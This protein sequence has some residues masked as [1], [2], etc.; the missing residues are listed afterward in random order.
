M[1]ICYRTDVPLLF[2]DYLYFYEVEILNF[3]YVSFCAEVQKNAILACVLNCAEIKQIM[4]KKILRGM[5]LK[6]FISKRQCK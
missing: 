6:Y 2:T 4:E 1:Y 5:C 3:S